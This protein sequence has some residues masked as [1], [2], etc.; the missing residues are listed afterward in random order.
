VLDELGCGGIPRLTVYNKCD[1]AGAVPFDP[2]I[3]LTSARTGRGLD[4]LKTRL[5]EILAAVEN[6]HMLFQVDQGA[7]RSLG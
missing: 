3:L 6:D 2:D 4:A 5:D 1:K 7:V